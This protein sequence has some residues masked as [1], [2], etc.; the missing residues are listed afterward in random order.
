ML[1]TLQ[2]MD[3]QLPVAGPLGSGRLD[4]NGNEYFKLGYVASAVN[5]LT[6]SNAATGD[7]PSITASGDDSNVGVQLIPKGTAPIYI[8][9]FATGIDY[10]ISFLGET[11]IG[12]FK[13]ME[14]EDY[15]QFQD[16]MLFNSA[17]ELYFRATTQRIY[18][19]SSSTLYID[20]PTLS[21]NPN[22]AGD[23]TLGDGT[24]RDLY[25]N[26]DKK[27]DLGKSSNWFNEGWIHQLHVQQSVAN[28]SSPPTDAELDSAFGTPATLG[29]G[30]I[31][32]VDD[33]DGDATMWLCV[34]SDA[35]WYYV[36]TTKAV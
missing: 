15:F 3:S 14:D 6:F 4:P 22:N 7:N 27:I 18:S 20:A 32:T 13:W 28:V 21:L 25:P 16:G 11:T 9:N 36:A 24:Q 31:G 10:Q 35:S 5:E 26:T 17:E 34:T 30:F 8:G 23:I 12:I 19:P 29:R 1:R 2:T 33:N